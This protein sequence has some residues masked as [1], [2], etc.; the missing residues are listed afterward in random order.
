VFLQDAVTTQCAMVF[1]LGLLWK[2]AFE[3]SKRSTSNLLEVVPE[4]Q[5][6][7]NLHIHQG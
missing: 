3:T 1:F 5:G 6:K 2:I 4:I 7:R